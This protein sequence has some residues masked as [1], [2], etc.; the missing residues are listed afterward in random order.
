[1]RRG[2][3]LLLAAFLMAWEPMRIAAEYASAIGSVGMRGPT[4][5]LELL[6]HAAIAAFCVAS[7]W[8]LWN[9]NP[10]GATLARYAVAASAAVSVQ[11]LY[12][13]SLPHQTM[14]GERLPFA[15]LALAHATAW[16]VYLKRS[17]RVRAIF[18]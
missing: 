18:D 2:W 8:A 17:R 3:W 11:S 7:G 9:G 1:M 6:G 16:I 4:A 5:I 10:A 14:P 12:W 15:I 13:S